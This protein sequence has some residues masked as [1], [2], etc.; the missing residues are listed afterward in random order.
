MAITQTFNLNLIPSGAPIV[1]H[2]DQYDVGEG[3]LIAKLFKGDTEYTPGAGA[4]VIVQGK[5]PDG[6]GFMY[7]ATLSG[8]TVTMDLTEQMSIVA[9]RVCAQVV[10]DEGDDRTGTFVFFID[11]QM[12][13]LPADTDMSRSDYQLVEELLE[14]AQSISTNFPY[15]GANGNWWYYDVEAGEYV[16]SG[17]DASITVTVGT[18]TTLLPGSSATVTNR[19]T[20]TDP[21]LDFGIPRGADGTN[22]TDGQDGTSAGFGTPTASVD[23]NVGTPSVSISASGPD[24]AKIFEFAFHNL[25][26]S[27]GATGNGIV[28][29][30]K[31]GTAGLVDTYTI[32]YTNGQ[33][34]TFTVTNGQDGQGS[35]DM[36]KAVY[37]SSNAVADA[38]GIVAYINGLSF[39]KYLA[40]YGQSTIDTADL[41]NF[42][43]PGTYRKTGTGL[44]ANSPSDILTADEYVL[45]VMGAVASKIVGDSAPISQIMIAHIASTNETKIYVRGFAGRTGE[46]IVT[47][48][49]TSW[50][51]LNSPDISGK[52]DKV[53]SATNG[54]FA[55]LDANGNLT[56]S[57]VAPSDLASASSVT[58]I[59]GK[60]PSTASSSNKMAT[61][62]DITNVYEV[63]GQNGAKNYAYPTTTNNVTINGATYSYDDENVVNVNKDSVSTSDSYYEYCKIKMPKGSYLVSGCEGGSQ[64]TFYFILRVRNADDTADE[65]S[66]FVYDGESSTFTVPEDNRYV[67]IYIAVF[68]NTILTDKKLYP[69]IRLASDPDDTYQPYAMTNR[70]LTEIKNGT[71]TS[72][73]TWNGSL[74]KCGNLVRL[75][76]SVATGT[77]QVAA[78]TALATLEYKPSNETYFFARSNIDGSIRLACVYPN[79][80]VSINSALSQGGNLLG[81]VMYFLK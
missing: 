8:N 66:A 10:V 4:T 40:Q 33:S 51:C 25:K 59:E 28:S 57:G 44:K 54:N 1:I 53:S 32:L 3:R 29:I 31:T 20:A 48:N 55:G 67:K 14:T 15:I 36:T 34:T 17:V 58:A 12:S 46:I 37:D 71:V 77:S 6:H 60:I 5:K 45:V 47:N 41:N 49:W 74:N 73:Y 39:D 21:I 18:T 23:G 30:T 9:G 2:C 80:T 42:V 75:D 70:E 78:N 43:T 56:D 69:M 63:M 22:G 24:T 61:A 79:G 13:A 81:S 35:G 7:A 52:A 65:S 26:G 62:S 27:D 38:G 16:D 76:F 72:N 19:G 50:V 11:V 68:K 64:S